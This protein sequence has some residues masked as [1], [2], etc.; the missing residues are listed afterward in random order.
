M[1]KADNCFETSV[2]KF[3]ETLKMTKGQN[4]RLIAQEAKEK[5]NKELDTLINKTFDKIYSMLEAAAQSGKFELEIT[6]AQENKKAFSSF[7]EDFL[8][9]IKLSSEKLTKKFREEDIN[10]NL[11]PISGNVYKVKF[12][13]KPEINPILYK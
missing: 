10:I 2:E 13:W 12:E 5:A 3:D 11:I 7:E 1:N 9:I 6:T 8:K 4:L